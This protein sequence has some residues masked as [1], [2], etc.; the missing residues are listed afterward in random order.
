MED[1]RDLCMTSLLN[2]RT[3]LKHYN[4]VV[5]HHDQRIMQACAQ[6]IMAS[7]SEIVDG[8]E[9]A[10]EQLIELEYENFVGTISN[11][12][13][14]I[15][16][17]E[18]LIEIVRRYIQARE[19]AGPKKPTM[20]EQLVKPDLWALLNDEEKQSRQTAFE[21]EEAKKKAAK[22]EAM[23][24]EAE[25][26]IKKDPVDKIQHVLD[27]KQ[28]DRNLKIYDDTFHKVKLNDA[29]KERLMQSIRWQYLSQETLL[30]L[31]SDPDFVLAKSLIVQGL[32]VKL[33][34]PGAISSE[35]SKLNTKPRDSYARQ[36]PDPAI[37]V[38][39]VDEMALSAQ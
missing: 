15:N 7:F 14:G 39:V 36:T 11:D 19:Q 2:E 16:D 32:A 3:V 31:S 17:E 9:G 30:K 26:Y 6:I 29:Q 28:K 18:I 37:D 5:E 12:A 34:G 8:G 22:E 24:A 10:L 1:L 38:G 4:D 23:L 33:G 13:L 21:E 27:I 25:E 20:A 35:D